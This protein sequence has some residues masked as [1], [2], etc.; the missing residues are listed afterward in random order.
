MDFFEI[1][2][3]YVNSLTKGERG[4]FDY[5]I[6]HMDEIKNKSIREVSAACFVSTTTFLRFV[7]K[8]GYTGYSE[9][10]TVL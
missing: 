7:R 3:K 2:S 5:V 4:L 1:S 9:F 6:K 8:I 10:T